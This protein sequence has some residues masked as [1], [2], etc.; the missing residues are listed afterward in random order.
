MDMYD[1]FFPEQAQASHLRKLAR[2]SASSRVIKDPEQSQQIR[3]LQEDVKFLTLVLAAI[4]RRLSETETLNL[5]D[6]Q[7]LLTEIDG[8]DGVG[9]SGLDPGVL[10]G[11]LGVLKKEPEDDKPAAGDEFKIV[12]MPRYRKR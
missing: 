5:A 12:T 1:F 11:L 8:L 9:D 3:D 10:R 4:V 7:D 2:Q 6:I